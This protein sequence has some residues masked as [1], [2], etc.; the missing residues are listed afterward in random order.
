M[1]DLAHELQWFAALMD[2]AANLIERIPAE[3]FDKLEGRYFLCDELGGAAAMARDA[4][5]D[6][7]ESSN[8]PQ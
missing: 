3:V 4:A 7:E 1:K 8:E 5:T 2:E 6:L